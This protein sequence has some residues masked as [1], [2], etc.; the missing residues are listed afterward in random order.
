M[1]VTQVEELGLV[2]LTKDLK[3]L[4][5]HMDRVQAKQLVRSYYQ[6]QDARMAYGKRAA[7]NEKQGFGHAVIEFFEGQNEF[8]ERQVK[9][10]IAA[11][12]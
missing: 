3:T 2:K 5:H 7:A 6:A 11:Y 9:S 12:A 10:A 8:Q 1:E 4:I